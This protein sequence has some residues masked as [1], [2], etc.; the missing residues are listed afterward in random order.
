[1][2]LSYPGPAASGQSAA[3]AVDEDGMDSISTTV[4]AQGSGYLV[5]ADADQIGWAATVDGKPAALVPA[6]E[7]LVAVAVPAGNHTVALHF[8]APHGTFAYAASVATAIGL[9]AVVLGEVWWTRSRRRRPAR[10]G[11]V[12]GG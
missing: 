8:A 1:V 6:D 10:T 12:A 9:V 5:V 3:V 2:L 4:D 11:P 7:G